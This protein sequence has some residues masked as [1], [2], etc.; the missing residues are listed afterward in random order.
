MVLFFIAFHRLNCLRGTDSRNTNGKPGAMNQIS[1]SLNVVTIDLAL[2]FSGHCR[3]NR[4]DS[5]RLA[6]Q[7]GAV[8]GELFDCVTE[9]VTKIEFGALAF[10]LFASRETTPAL[11]SQD[12]PTTSATVSGS[13][14]LNFSISR[15]SS[16]K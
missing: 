5:H 2:L 4:P 3:Q 15:S 16:S 10:L 7:P 12:R 13:S 8:A 11:I 9:C 14:A 6:V 1:N